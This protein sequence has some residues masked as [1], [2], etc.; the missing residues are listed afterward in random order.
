MQR[1]L[2]ETLNL[3]GSKKKILKMLSRKNLGREGEGGAAGL[4]PNSF[5][6]ISSINYIFR[7]N[8]TIFNA[9]HIEM[10]CFGICLKKR[11]EYYSE[12]YIRRGNTKGR[13]KN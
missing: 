13:G 10:V 8:K 2:T 7:T 6:Q 3:N 5:K 11:E 9:I 1:E 4:T 12:I